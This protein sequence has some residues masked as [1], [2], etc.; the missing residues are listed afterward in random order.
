MN[1]PLVLYKNEIMVPDS[2]LDLTHRYIGS[3]CPLEVHR[4]YAVGNVNLERIDRYLKNS[5][6]LKQR[7]P[8][9]LFNIYQ[10]ACAQEFRSSTLSVRK[11]DLLSA[12]DYEESLFKQA[13]KDAWPI[14]QSQVTE[15]FEPMRLRFKRD[16]WKEEVDRGDH[17]FWP[18]IT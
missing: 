8:K 6:Y 12:V 14:E 10:A 1:S 7:W 17:P 2:N 15:I 18:G 13:L 9:W 16:L 11:V 5:F 4:D 3:F